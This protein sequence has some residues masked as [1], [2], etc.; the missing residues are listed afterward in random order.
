MFFSQK[1]KI[2]SLDVVDKTLHDMGNQLSKERREEI[3]V[4]ILE[5]AYSIGAS[6]K[7]RVLTQILR[8]LMKDGYFND[9]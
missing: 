9:Q 8:T 4:E 5:T 3:A 6:F 7:P 1:D 2:T